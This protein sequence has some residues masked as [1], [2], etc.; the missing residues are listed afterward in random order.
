MDGYYK[1]TAAHTGKSLTVKNNNIKA[2]EQIVQD[3][4][5]SEIGQ[6][7][8]IRDSNKNG[9]IISPLS[10]PDMCIT[11]S[12]NIANG[13]KLTL[14]N[15]QY[16]N[17][18]MFYVYSVNIGANIN[19]NKY[20][21]ISELVNKLVT[22]HPNWEFQ[23]LYTTID[24]NKAVQ[25]EYE[26]AGKQGNLVYTPTYKGDWIAPNPYVSGNWASA[27]YKGIAYFMDSRNFLNDIDVFQF[28][29]LGDYASSGATLASIQYQVNDTF[30]QKHAE[31]LIK[32]CKN[33]NINPYYVLARLFQEQGQYGSITI[34]MDGGDGKKYYNP[35]NIS[36][37][38][39]DDF[40]TALA[41]AKKEGWDTMA[42]GLEGGMRILKS[43]YIDVKQNTLYLNKFDVNPAS[44]GGFYNHQYMQNLSAAYSE[45][46]ILRGA[47]ADTGTLDCKLKFIIPVYENMPKTVSAKPTGQG[48]ATLDI[49]PKNVKVINA[50]SGLALRKSAS[51]SGDL[52]ERLSTGTVLLSVERLSN[53]WSKVM[54]PSGNV[55][56]CSSSY[57]QIIAD[58]TNCKDRV[59]ISTND[60]S[61]TNVRI[62]PG[63]SFEIIKAIA[64]GKTGTRILTGKYNYNGYWWDEVIFDD[65]TKGFVATN[66]LK[67]IN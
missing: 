18:Q 31:D 17:T 3:E 29:D 41:R 67:K 47:Y 44:G 62:G 33:V 59:M 38:V 24:F 15:L 35:F 2:G 28:L 51:T 4:Y 52:I 14:G 58:V 60:K 25:S 8:I 34:N 65:G 12:G 10:R 57:L 48:Q 11:I 5:K 1:I 16:S 32:A 46:R 39:G 40:A 50:D 23:V 53:G 26:Y 27:S 45:A 49:G 20:P 42:K 6:K 64:D 61:G 43:Y 7:W 36:A 63:T 55:G 22:A 9:W 56:Y 37:V 21:G 66:Y 54:A 30:L 19:S 13:A